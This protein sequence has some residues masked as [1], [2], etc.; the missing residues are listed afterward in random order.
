MRNH[1]HGGGVV[2]GAL[3][4]LSVASARGGDDW[5][6]WVTESA[7]VGLTNGVGIRVEIE[8]RWRD[9]AR[10]F[11]RY[12]GQLQLDF[13][14]SDRVTLSPVIRELYWLNDKTKD[15]KELVCGASA[16]AGSVGKAEPGGMGGYPSIEDFLQGLRH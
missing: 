6:L 1:I 7:G 13:Q 9:D 4:F 16:Y 15:P 5:E 10:E 3:L 11:Y 14:I 2:L 12:Y 8:S